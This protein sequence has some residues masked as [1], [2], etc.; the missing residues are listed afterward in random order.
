MSDNVLVFDRWKQTATASERFSELEALARKWPH[1]F[2]KVA[3]VYVEELDNG[4]IKVRY[5]S[6][7][8]KTDELMGILELGKMELYKVTS[9]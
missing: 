1:Q 5:T 6:S 4:D 3:V 7:G 9:R 2:G 8:C